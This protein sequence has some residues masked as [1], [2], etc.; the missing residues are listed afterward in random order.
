VIGTHSRTLRT[1]M[2]LL[3]PS[4]AGQLSRLFAHPK[5][6]DLYPEY[7]FTL[8]CATRASVPL[9]EAA[10]HRSEYLADSDPVAAALVVYLTRHIPEE[11]HSHWLLEDLEV[12]G[13]CRSSVHSRIPSPTLASFVGAQYYWIHH[14]HPVSLLGY[15]ELAEG[16]P[17]TLEQ[18]DDLQ[19]S[20]GYPSE[21]F[22]SLRRH[23]H[24]DLEHRDDLHRVLDGL[25]LTPTQQELI[26]LS[27]L[28]SIDLAASLI[29]DI[30]SQSA[31]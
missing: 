9:M 22:R 30:E 31:L 25:P 7:L 17:P 16:Y 23:S 6:A 11:M 29:H 5:I 12:L 3:L 13:I 28:H 20:T 24:L 8:H 15:M 4:L 1:K 27:A 21:A 2:E 10:L 26:G 19:K 14:F 18:L